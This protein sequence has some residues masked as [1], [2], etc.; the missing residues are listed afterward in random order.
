[1]VKIVSGESTEAAIVEHFPPNEVE[2][3]IIDCM[4]LC[5]LCVCHFFSMNLTNPQ[6]ML[7]DLNGPQPP[8]G[9]R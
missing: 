6:R 7:L 2:G 9:L 1:M 4:L 5:N 8:L 3:H